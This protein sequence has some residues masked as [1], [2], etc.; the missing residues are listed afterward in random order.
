MA[1]VERAWSD[2]GQIER[3]VTWF[4]NTHDPCSAQRALEAVCS[5]APPSVSRTLERRQRCWLGKPQRD[6]ERG[7]AL[8]VAARWHG[9][10]MCELAWCGCDIASS[11]LQGETGM[12][13]SL[14]ECCVGETWQH[15]FDTMST[16]WSKTFVPVLP[17]RVNPL[18]KTS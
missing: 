17:N 9:V 11:K 2:A 13:C 5:R 4:D 7:Q 16:C 1:W 3:V 12:T 8:Q 18:A 15:E 10:S 14:R 6:G